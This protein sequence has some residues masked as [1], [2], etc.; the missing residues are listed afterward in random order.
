MMTSKMTICFIMLGSLMKNR[1]VNNMNNT[2]IATM[3]RHMIFQIDTHRS[4][5]YLDWVRR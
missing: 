4:A 1:V 5:I 2:F 3:Y